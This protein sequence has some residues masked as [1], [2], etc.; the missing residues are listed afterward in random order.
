MKRYIA[1]L[2]VTVLLVPLLAVPVW[3]DV[4]I[5]SDVIGADKLPAGYVYP[6]WKGFS[7]E[8]NRTNTGRDM[9]FYDGTNGMYYSIS[10]F[11]TVTFINSWNV[12]YLLKFSDPNSVRIRAYACTG[13]QLFQFTPEQCIT[14]TFPAIELESAFYGTAYQDFF[15]ALKYNY[16]NQ[17]PVLYRFE[18]NSKGDIVSMYTNTSSSSGWMSIDSSSFGS[19]IHIPNFQT[20]IEA[21]DLSIA[22]S[23]VTAQSF[24]YYVVQKSDSDVTSSI[25]YPLTWYQTDNLIIG[26]TPVRGFPLAVSVYNT[27]SSSFSYDNGAYYRLDSSSRIVRLFYSEKMVKDENLKLETS[28]MNRFL[29]HFGYDTIYYSEQNAQLSSD[30][31]AVGGTIGGWA[32]SAGSYTSQANSSISGVKTSITSFQ[33]VFMGV[34]NI[35][36]AWFF[37][38]MAVVFVIVIGRKILG[39]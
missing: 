17:Y 1:A 33:T 24:D 26:N 13:R 3:A 16:P 28:I 34:W 37:S 22:L 31:D 6:Y 32:S 14:M 20:M 21:F 35:L 38:L 27:D 23:D 36:P 5:M 8:I 11:G 9:L 7:G 25:D 39:R 30:I 2:L 10:F 19:T 12:G 29:S 18:Y 4:L 15:G